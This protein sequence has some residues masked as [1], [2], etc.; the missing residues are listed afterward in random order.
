MRKDHVK[1]NEKNTKNNNSE[2]RIN[3]SSSDFKD[4]IEVWENED[5]PP[6]PV[7]PSHIPRKRDKI[8]NK[9]FLNSTITEK[10]TTNQ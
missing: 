3:F 8:R 9:K 1:I 2:T 6:K 7:L 4:I 5:T 10:L